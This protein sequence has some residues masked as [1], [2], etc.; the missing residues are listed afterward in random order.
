MTGPHRLA[1]GDWVDFE[2]DRHQ[3]V[4]FTS[5]AVRL[6]SEGGHTQI[7]LAGTLLADPTFRLATQPPEPAGD[8]ASLALDPEALLAGIDEAERRRVLDMQAH[9]LEVT[10]GYRSGTAGT[11]LPG[12][13]RPEHD[14]GR[15]LEQRI[16][17][18]AAELGI[19]PRWLWARLDA[20][21]T[22]GLWGLVDK[23]KTKPHNPLARL[24]PR[25]I[26]AI[27]DQA[28]AE[29]DDNAG[30]LNRYYRRVQNR[31]DVTHGA[32]QVTLPSRDTFRR[33]VA[34]LL[35]QSPSGPT[36]RRRSAA[37]QPDRVFAPMLAHRPGQ[38]VLL[39]TTPLDVLAYSPAAD[40][41]YPIELTVALDVA[42]RSLLAWLLTPRGT[43]G[44]DVGVL[45]ADVMTPE[46]MRPGWK[47]A[48]RYSMMRLPYQR[49]L[50]IDARLAE[51]AARP[52]VFPETLVYDHGK[53][54]QANTLRRACLRL[55]INAQDARQMT[56]TDKAMV[57]RVFGTIRTQF[58]EHVAGYKSYDVAHRGRDV[59]ATA[60]WSLSELAEFF[61]EYVVA[62]YQRQQHDGLLVPDFP[63]ARL[64]PNDAYALALTFTGYVAC[65]T[66]P[67]LYYELLP[68]ERRT[69][70]PGGVEI[71]NLVYSADVLTRYRGSRS[72]YPD[73]KWPIRHDPRNRLHAYFHD[74]ADG[75][76]HILDWTRAPDGCQP[77]TDISLREAKRIIAGR[78]RGGGEKTE[79]DEVA[80]A[81]L[82]LQN[83]MD[84]PES[85]TRTDRR[86][87][88]RDAERA[89]AAA[90]DRDRADPP[91]NAAEI[92]RPPALRVVP[93]LKLDDEFDDDTFDLG[94]VQAAEVWDPRARRAPQGN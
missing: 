22:T 13:P 62:V 56:P 4:G 12:E 9:L 88:A 21:R 90:R 67:N 47:D 40:T 10:T 59:E 31:L 15:T 8:D 34:L 41:T 60:R 38:T 55:G 77:F 85:W 36:V 83:R 44:I 87:Q 3:V 54:Y 74:P 80:E 33:A 46:P 18:K 68:I 50:D 73:G 81:L 23:R 51:A 19:T 89:R 91:I 53:P 5:A 78:R 63:E 17:A 52:V 49:L 43:K 25:I 32:G 30:T 16:T 79:Q 29:R 27:R 64:S 28:A 76:W 71:D 94:A 65:P 86:R 48:L 66:D 1:V 11:A 70:Q 75:S 45:L 7:I 20:W 82:A 26:D 2:D 39:D 37:N 24:D 69:I 6:R 93:D 84:A 61:A 35:G 14:P 92:A 72:P 42:T 58:S 57:E